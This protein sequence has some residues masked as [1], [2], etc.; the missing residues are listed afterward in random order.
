[1]TDIEDVGLQAALRS[2]GDIVRRKR[3]ACR[4]F[5]R[6]LAEKTGIDI[7][8]LSDV[9]AGIDALTATERETLCEFLGIDI[10]TF[11]KILRNERSKSV[12]TDVDT[13]EQLRSAPVVDLTRYRET[14]QTTTSLPED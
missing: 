4:W 6:E 12:S 11:P 8:S 7:A 10:D 2:F 9:E 1:M 14:W 5:F 13:R 3:Q